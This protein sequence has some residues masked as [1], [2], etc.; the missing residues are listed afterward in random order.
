MAEYSKILEVSVGRPV[1]IDLAS[2]TLV[3][4][5]VRI[6]GA[7]VAGSPLTK[8]ILDNLISL[9]DGTTTASAL[10][11]DA[12]GYSNFTPA[13]ATVRGALQGIDSALGGVAT[14][15]FS[16]ASFYVYNSVDNTK[17]IALSA[18]NITTGTTRTITMPDA[19]VDLGNLTNSNISGSAAISYSKLSLTSSIVNNDISASAAIAYGKLALT[20]SIVDSDIS[21]TAGISLSKLAALSGSTNAVLTRSSGGLIQ[22]SSIL[23][24]NLFL[25]DG[26]VTAA[27]TFTTQTILPAAAAT[28]NLGASGNNWLNV[29]ANTVNAGTINRGLTGTLT[30]QTSGTASGIT[31]QTIAGNIKLAPSTFVVDMSNSALQ[32]LLDPTNP[33]DAATKHYVD[34]AV[35]GLSW[36]TDVRAASTGS[37]VTVSSAPATL[38]GVSLAANDR[39]L[40]KDQTAGAENGIYVFNGAGSALTRAT[41]MS[42]WAE[43]V[44]SVM[45]VTEG[46][47]NAGSKWV[48]SNVAGGTLGTTAITFAAF[49]VAGTVNGT[50]TSGYVAYWN[51]TATLTAEQYLSPA[52]GGLGVNASAFT[53]VVKASGGSFS[54]SALVNADVAAGAAIAYSKLALSGS[55]VNADISTSAAIAYSKLALTNSIQAADLTTGVADQK[56]ITGGNGTALSVAQAPLVSVPLVAGQAFSA[57]TTYLVRWALNGETAGRVYAADKDASAANKYMAFGIFNSTTG[58]SAGQTINVVTLGSI[59]LGSSD[60]AFLAANVGLELFVGSAGAIILGSALAGTT[61]EAAVC[62]GVVQNTNQIWFSGPQLRGIS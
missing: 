28:Y 30:I 18:V 43:V 31:M 32:N 51:G 17:K 26:T 24:S 44:G 40:L 46:S 19:N 7:G 48:N 9:Q 38:D 13:A 39:I 22:A 45:L 25:A 4:Q 61:N 37:N 50:G 53:G 35:A 57:N 14:G 36:K 58:I 42:T 11:G 3:A 21:A 1:T 59:T 5:I 47:V 6:G 12:G 34:N 27:G 54:A 56:T 8:A 41:D 60:T 23:S 55:I 16:D 10:I 52:R 33:Q 15:H 62:V 20:G 29:Y 49:S 2:N